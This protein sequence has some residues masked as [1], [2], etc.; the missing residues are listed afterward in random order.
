MESITGRLFSSHT[1]L[2]VETFGR[3]YGRHLAMKQYISEKRERAAKGAKDRELV[4]T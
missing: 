2:V 4:A 3:Y 1:K